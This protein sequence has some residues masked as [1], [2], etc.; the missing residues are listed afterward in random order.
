MKTVR[1]SLLVIW[2]AC[3][4]TYDDDLGL[5]FEYNVIDFPVS[6]ICTDCC[7]LSKQDYICKATVPSQVD[8][9]KYDAKLYTR[10]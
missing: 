10:K 4:Y 2:A 9:P 7:T 6:I 3:P 1:V 5:L 8:S